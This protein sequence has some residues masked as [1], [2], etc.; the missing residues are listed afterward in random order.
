MDRIWINALPVLAAV[1]TVWLT[2]CQGSQNVRVAETPAGNILADAVRLI[3]KAEGALVPASALRAD[4]EPAQLAPAELLIRMVTGQDP[5]VV[6][7]LRGSQL[8]A[9][10]ERSV[11]YVGKP[12]AGFLQVSG[13]TLHADGSRPVGNRLVSVTVAGNPLDTAKEYRI[14][15][16]KPLADGQLGYFQFW[17]KQQILQDT[18]RTLEDAVKELAGQA[19]VPRGVESRIRIRNEG[20]SQ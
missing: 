2:P 8:R 6:V 13:I 10:L 9:A 16:P 14:A 19:P 4:S 17:T 15:M 12:F 3:G 5:V 1:S 7:R 20:K 18:G 11:T